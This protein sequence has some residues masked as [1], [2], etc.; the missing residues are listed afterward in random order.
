M[1]ESNLGCYV[2]LCVSSTEMSPDDI[3]AH[4][5]L[6]P[7]RKIVMGTPTGEDSPAMHHFHIAFFPSDLSPWTRMDVHI[8]QMLS[9]VEARRLNL[10]TIQDRC[11]VVIHCSAIVRDNN[12]W[13]LSP[14]LLARM[15]RL[16][17][18]FCFAVDADNKQQSV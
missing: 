18:A 6:K 17:I 15:G 5:G 13:E 3:A 2:A 9:V 1:P 7:S 16:N 12:G 10:R 4:L 14:D 11:K 8:E